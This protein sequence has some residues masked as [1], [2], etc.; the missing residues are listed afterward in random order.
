MLRKI[1][2]ANRGEIALRIIRACREMGIKTVAV[3]SEADAESLH[4]RFADEDVCIGPPPPAESYLDA[5]RIISAAEVTNSDAIHPGYGFLAESAEFAEICRSC[6]IAFIGPSP[7]VI[8]D[9][10]DKSLAREKMRAAGVPVIPGSEKPLAA[11]E[12]AQQLAREIGYPTII[13]AVGGGGGRGMRICADE[14]DFKNNF[15]AARAEAEAAF[16]NPAIYLEKYLE[17]PRHVEIQILGDTHGNVLHLGERDCTVQRR[18][19]K[20]IEESPSVAVNPVLRQALGEV[21]VQAAAAV[22]YYSTGTVEFLLDGRGNLYFMEM[23]TR[24]Q[25]EHPVTEE[26]TDIDLVKEQIRVAAGEKL[27]LR[28]SDVTFQGH[29]IEVRINAEDPWRNFAPRPGRI[30]SFH[31]P[32]GHGI[33]VDTH[34]YAKYVIPPYYDSLI[35]KL[36]AHG[37]TRS[38]A[39]RKLR[40]ALDEFIVEGIP[41]TIDFYKRVL[42][43][44][45][46]KSG[47]YDTSFIERYLP[48]LVE[49][50]SREK[51]VVETGSRS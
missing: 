10:G 14:K 30:T 47:E 43:H 23:N 17:S 37:K 36:I 4:V 41:T 20:L 45:V 35:A 9:M 51:P 18:H 46:F 32:G 33:R 38:E 15:A 26:Q 39:L 44:E 11:L 19:Q 27:E 2:I 6:G 34:A 24:I 5:K 7:E 12:E 3:Y 8:R 1:L 22:G 49:A 31:V 25:V 40:R 28:Q 29:T 50:E 42:D 21:A 13:K 48:E 16:G